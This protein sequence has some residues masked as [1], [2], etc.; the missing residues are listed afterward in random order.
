MAEKIPEGQTRPYFGVTVE[1]LADRLGANMVDKGV[2]T[3]LPPGRKI[4]DVEWDGKHGAVLFYY[5]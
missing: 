2:V 3:G 4:V 1:L 5:E